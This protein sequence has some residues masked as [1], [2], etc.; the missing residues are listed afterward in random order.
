MSKV[1][2]PLNWNFWHLSALGSVWISLVTLGSA[3]PNLSGPLTVSVL[4]LLPYNS[5]IRLQ[6]SIQQPVDESLTIGLS[7]SSKEVT[8]YYGLVPPSKTSQM[9]WDRSPNLT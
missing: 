9:Y 4:R 6:M 8:L 1:E 5:L 2:G 3:N 7:S